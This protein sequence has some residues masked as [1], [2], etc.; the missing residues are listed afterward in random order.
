MEFLGCQA[1]RCLV[2]G[3]VMRELGG[4]LIFAEIYS[5][6]LPTKRIG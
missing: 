2:I 3:L 6:I 5:I 4:K 1:M